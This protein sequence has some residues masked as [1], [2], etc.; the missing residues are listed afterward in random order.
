MAGVKG[1]TNSKC[2]AVKKKITYKET[3]D[4]CSKCGGPLT[5][6]CKK[7]YTP[8]GKKEK[9]CARHQAEKE[10]KADKV[11]KTAAQAG[12]A[13]LS[14]GAVVLTKGKDIAKYIPKLK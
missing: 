3:E 9:L 2:V 8:I 10:D 12:G 5:Y 6:V 11:M 4:F 1:C 7:C 13:V 14:V